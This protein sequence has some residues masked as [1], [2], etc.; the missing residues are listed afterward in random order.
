LNIL[1][2]FSLFSMTWVRMQHW[3]PG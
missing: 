3:G 1:P 2:L